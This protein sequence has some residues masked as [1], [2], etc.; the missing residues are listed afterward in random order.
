MN[1]AEKVREQ[2][3][4]VRDGLCPECET[5]L[6]DVPI[7]NEITGRPRSQAGVPLTRRACPSCGFALKAKHG[8]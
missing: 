7:I 5:E 4:R 8:R 2:R 3:R 1:D 6:T